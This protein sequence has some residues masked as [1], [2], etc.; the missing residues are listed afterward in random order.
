ML[1]VIQEKYLIWFVMVWLSKGIN[2]KNMKNASLLKSSLLHAFTFRDFLVFL[3]WPESTA[4]TVR[5]L[6]VSINK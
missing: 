5:N 6:K 3:L 2:D 1:P 4:P